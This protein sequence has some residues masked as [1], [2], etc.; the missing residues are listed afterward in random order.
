[1]RPRHARA[2]RP[3]VILPYD[4]FGT[5]RELSLCGRV[6]RGGALPTGAATD[7]AW[8]NLAA[9]YHRFESDEVP[10][11]K[12]RARFRGIEAEASADHEGYFSL[13]VRPRAPVAAGR[14]HE[15]ALDLVEPHAGAGA[16]GRVLVPS[17]RARFGVISDI[18]DTVVESNVT[19]KV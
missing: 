13:S 2:R 6:L 10:R 16:T 11:A 3:L 14:W 8:R 1:M 7:R 15:I 12:V 17:A 18:D 4:G 9:M 5:A 19:R